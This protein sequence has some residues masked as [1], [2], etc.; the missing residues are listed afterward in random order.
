[1]GNLD[2]AGH[3]LEK[4]GGVVYYTAGLRLST[5]TGISKASLALLTCDGIIILY[6]IIVYLNIE[7]ILYIILLITYPAGRS[8]GTPVL[9]KRGSVDSPGKETRPKKKLYERSREVSGGRKTG[10]Q[11]L[12]TKRQ[13]KRQRLA[14]VQERRRCMA[15]IREFDRLDLGRINEQLHNLVATDGDIEV[16]SLSLGFRAYRVYRC[17]LLARQRPY[18]DRN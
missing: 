3:A 5:D 2:P 18:L 17:C 10:P 15:A 7:I 16:P 11:P 8:A 4:R 1:M 14:E 12:L 13:L 6:I 9:G